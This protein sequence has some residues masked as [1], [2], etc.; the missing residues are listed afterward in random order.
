MLFKS[1]FL[2]FAFGPAF[3]F[4]MPV[5]EAYRRIPHQQTTFLVQESALPKEEAQRLA[6][7]FELVDQAIVAKVQTQAWLAA[8]RRD[9][10]ARSVDDYKK[11]LAGLM[12]EMQSLA[13]P[14]GA[15]EASQLVLQALA[16]QE[17]Y[18]EAQQRMANRQ[19]GSYQ[20]KNSEE[21]QSLLH[22]SSA[23]LHKAY[24]ELMQHFTAESAH[25]QGAFYSHLC[26][27]DF[28]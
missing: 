17:Q 2:A 3:A 26:A 19:F 8:N 7:F 6:R 4:S 18:F 25:N 24:A 11:T 14:V 9:P 20:A 15:Q 23:K 28:L 22:S 27:L 12:K 10:E 13:L 16:E 5:A 21:S 1:L